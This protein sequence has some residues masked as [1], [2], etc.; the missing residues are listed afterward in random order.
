MKSS[1]LIPAF[2][3]A[4]I[5]AGMY[6]EV[7]AFLFHRRTEEI[8]LFALLLFVGIGLGLDEH[9]HS[10]IKS[11]NIKILLVPLAVITGT[12]AGT[13]VYALFNDI[14]MV[15]SLAIGSGFGWYSL[16]SIL[17]AEYAGEELG[18]TALVANITREILT[19]MLAPFMVKYFGKLAP[20]AS[21]GATSMDT[22]LPV[23]SKFSGKDYILISVFNGIIL[24][25][26]VPV[27]IS[28]L[29]KF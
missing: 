21:G 11:V 5:L 24:S 7:P 13:A 27:I 26:L 18:V 9:F 10:I 4:G 2:F 15:D 25:L 8:I 29:Y 3:S 23:V 19:L 20:I 1:L 28:L 17:I 12:F 14:R 16:S 22:T 6:A